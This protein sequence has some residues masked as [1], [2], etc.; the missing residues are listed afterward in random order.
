MNALNAQ[1]V[2]AQYIQLLSNIYESSTSTIQLGR[3]G[4]PFPIKR[5]VRQGDTIS[6]KF[7]ISCLQQAFNKLKDKWNSKCYGT[8]IGNETINNLRF[9]ADDIILVAKTPRELQQMLEDLH[10]MSEQ[11]GLKMNKSKTRSCSIRRLRQIK[12]YKLKDRN[13]NQCKAMFSWVNYSR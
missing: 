8:K 6:S 1:K 13:W 2:P 11:I 12:K 3:E 10:A 5:G 4:E 9:A 7:F